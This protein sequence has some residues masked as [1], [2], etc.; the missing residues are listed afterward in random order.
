LLEVQ[1][2]AN[3]TV[4]HRH[5]TQLPQARELRR[6]RREDVFCSPEA[7]GADKTCKTIEESGYLQPEA[8]VSVIEGLKSFLNVVSIESIR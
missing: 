5:G 6:L 7:N 1:V 2:I 4:R 3:Q 8:I